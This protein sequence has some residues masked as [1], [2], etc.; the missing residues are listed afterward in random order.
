[1]LLPVAEL[2]CPEGLF[3]FTLERGDRYPHRL[4]DTGRYTHHIDHVREVAAEA[5]L[6]VARL[7]EAFLRTEYGT[8]RDRAVCG[9]SK[10]Q[11]PAQSEA[12]QRRFIRKPQSAAHSG[13][14]NSSLRARFRAER[15][16]RFAAV[17]AALLIPVYWHRRI[18]A[19]DLGSHLYNAWLAQLIRQGQAPGLWIARQWNNVVRSAS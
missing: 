14:G 9:R 6:N 19:G 11:S 12:R 15:R 17:S 8:P 18:E 16:T 10:R 3:A 7:E 2:L 5:K 1:M 13:A 4:T